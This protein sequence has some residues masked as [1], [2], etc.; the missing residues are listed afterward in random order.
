MS[1]ASVRH[2]L[3]VR[4][5]WLRRLCWRVLHWHSRAL[6]WLA[7]VIV[8]LAAGGAGWLQWWFFPHLDSYRPHLVSQLQTLTG[9]PVDIGR[10]TGGWQGVSPYLK[11]EQLAL[12][13]LDG[14]A[15]LS[16]A[17][18]DATLSWWPLVLGD[19]RFERL[20]AIRPD[21]EISRDVDGVIR[22]AGMPLSRDKQDNGLGNWILRQHDIAIVDGR[23][24]WQDTQRHAPRLTLEHVNLSLDNLLFGHHSLQ[25]TATPPV[26]L[27]APFSLTGEWRGD[28]INQLSEW[29]GSAK[30]VLSQVDLAAWSAWL[31]YPVEVRRGKGRLD[32]QLAF[33]N[34]AISDL[35]AQLALNAAS[36]R[37]APEL[38]FLD[39][40]TLAGNVHWQDQHGERQVHVTDLKLSAEH[41]QLLDGSQASLVMHATGGGEVKA[42][43]LTLPALA[44]LP[45]ALPLPNAIR[46]ELAGMQL[47]GKI[48]TLDGHWQGDWREPSAYGG[49]VAF[50]GLGLNAPAPWPT[51]GP[52]DGE[53]NLD[54]Q[55]GRLALR[56][57]RFRLSLANFLAQP[58][59]LDRLRLGANWR[60]IGKGWT[61]NLT[62]FSAVNADLDANATASWQWP[63]AGLGILKLNA[64][65]PRLTANKVA[66]YLPLVIGTDTRTWLKGALV[67]GDAR[68]ARFVLNGPLADF[69]FADGKTGL[70]EVVTQA[71]GV[72]LDYAP[73]WPAVTGLDGEVRIKGNQLTVA[74]SGRILGTRVER[75]TASIQ[76]LAT[77]QGIQIDG[78][79][80]GPTL[81]FFH[82][83]A[84]SPLDKTLGGLGTLARSTGDGQLALKLD[85][86][87]VNADNTKVS[88]SYRVVGN[89]LQIGDAMPELSEVRGDISFTERGVTAKGLQVKAL[90]GTSKVDIASS[91]DGVVTVSAVGRADAGLAVRRYGIPF[92][93]KV[94]GPTDY[95]LQIV[96]PK[97]GW[98]LALE[99][100][101]R[102]T[103]IDLP[104]PLT[105][106]PGEARLLRLALEEGEKA[107]RWRVALGNQLNIDLSRVPGPNGWRIDRGEVHLGAGLPN[108]ASRG[109]WITASLPEL[110]VDP[111]LRLLD[112]P[113]ANM[114][115]ESKPAIAGVEV[116]TAKLIV[117]GNQLDDVLLRAVPQAE[118]VWQLTASS[119]QIEGRAD[120]SPQGKGKVRARLNRLILPLADAP[121]DAVTS[122]SKRDNPL[123][124]L[125]VVAEDFRYREHALGRLEVKAQQQRENW[126]IDSLTLVNPDGKLSMQGLWQ[127]GGEDVGTRVKVDI[128]SDNVGKLL[129]RFGYPE[130][131]RRGSGNIE[132]DLAWRGSPLNPDYASMSGKMHLAANSGQFA[133]FEPG[134]GRLLGILSLQSLQRR[135]TL[136]FR[137][138]FS[139]G[140]AFDRIEGDSKIAHGVMTTD[141]LTIVGPAAQ[142]LFQG[143]ADLG[144]ETQKLRVRIVP[145]IGDSLAVGAGVALA[146]PALAVGAYVLQRVLK[147]PF[148]RLIAYEYDVTGRWDDP[149]VVRVGDAPKK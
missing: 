27:S 136:D 140:F 85:I 118:G 42:T 78:N 47:T 73:N 107:E 30:T 121:E 2:P 141:N 79:V 19:L 99:S 100:T 147:D 108:V 36:L 8:L 96:L 14:S 68:D 131:M 106:A 119:K 76:D 39:V 3:I 117:A 84:Q 80:K 66:D 49:Q 128:S 21:L 132:A 31:P 94:S 55:G 111:W 26:A 41:G 11:F 124:A 89:K 23:L 12:K 120:W 48:N 59:A 25:V 7:A 71:R 75:A 87:F 137:D 148:G 34:G 13:Q 123:P 6:V 142:V 67:A 51:I 61:V 65:L 57:Q 97:K 50:S 102:D 69:P 18:V 133:K 122:A 63:G 74:A 4:L 45:P 1:P 149:Q 5:V 29:H 77:S 145:T 83:I 126:L 139:E 143:E 92:A 58:L 38:A 52:I 114:G 125:D 86:P 64:D 144:R 32:L 93:D 16:L 115:G 43:G 95:R 24:S 104:A 17:E 81:E 130:A 135:L 138:V 129:G 109:L 82:F 112:S 113:T 60:R 56:G 72:T 103:K 116:K 28:D 146:N 9:R 20:S 70:W 10:I 22:I 110:A 53:I 37:L 62:E 134:V 88:G 91:S 54:Q 33:A 35:R 90:G 127:P 98:Q 101:L 44:S 46:R 105:K 15:A 40:D